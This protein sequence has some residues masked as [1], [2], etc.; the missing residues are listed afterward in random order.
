MDPK[1]Y[2]V[3]NQD[4]WC[5]LL[6]GRP[7][8]NDTY[9]AFRKLN[10]SIGSNIEKIIFNN[11]T[12]TENIGSTIFNT[13]T[14]NSWN[15]IKIYFNVLVTDDL[16]LFSRYNNREDFDGAIANL[17]IYNSNDIITN[18]Y[19]FISYNEENK[20]LNSITNTYDLKIFGKYTTGK[21]HDL[22]NTDVLYN[23]NT[24]NLSNH[25]SLD[26]ILFLKKDSLDIEN[27]KFLLY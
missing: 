1:I 27:D 11:V 8:N 5:Y 15:T 20:F 21:I 14:K 25:N 22:N 18:S 10:I 3:Q 9:L 12:I 2:E 16:S 24:D 6:D 7:G 19:D 26:I 17:K 23:S 4:Y 13:I